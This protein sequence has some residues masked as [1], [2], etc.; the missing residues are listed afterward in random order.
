MKFLMTEGYDRTGRGAPRSAKVAAFYGIRYA[1]LLGG[2]RFSP[3]VPVQGEEQA[4]VERL[5]DVPVFPSRGSGLED[6]LG[7]ADTINPQSEDAFFLNVWAPDG[8]DGLPVVVFLHGGAWTSGGGSVQWYNGR[9]LAAGGLVVVTLNY[10]L[11]P[12]A[13]L[14][15]PA[16]GG[17]PTPSRPVQDIL[18]ALAWVQ[19]NISKCGGNP[20]RVTLAG[21]SAGGWYAHL[22]SV[23]PEARSLFERLALWSMGT[24][25]PRSTAVQARI[26]S[27]ANQRLS[28]FDV[29]SAPFR[30]LLDAGE[31]ALKSALPPAAFGHAAAGYVPH[32]TD[33]VPRDLLDPTSAA[34]LCS[35]EA[36]YAR[37][38]A[39]ETGTFFHNVPT[40]RHADSRR[41]QEWLE[42]LPA[43][44]LRNHVIGDPLWGQKSP[45]ERILAVSS[46]IQ[47]KS[48]PTSL[49]NEYKTVG[50]PAM[51]DE[52]AYR[53]AV[54]GQLS[55]HCLDLPFQFGTFDEWADAPMMRNCDV[56][57]FD[58]LSAHLIGGF[59]DFASSPLPKSNPVGRLI[60]AT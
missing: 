45:Y 58:E 10:R 16:V 49:V 23:L 35:A 5:T 12:V 59:T 60:T 7:R 42:S 8:A 11:G 20:G 17:R 44:S 34:K 43:G 25:T 52:F 3:P 28:P 15:P 13:H 46:W 32:E 1:A 37:Y 33:N 19:D 2:R 21:Q 51:I 41:V 55:G 4:D 30:E 22:L 47:Y 14:A 40:L 53:G 27:A 29:E 57:T 24:R 6:V 38:T 56:D 18:T 39:E 36:V 48:V 9:H 26:H 31:R 50:I 54:E